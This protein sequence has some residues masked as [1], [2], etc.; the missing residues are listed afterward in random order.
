MQGPLRVGPR[1]LKLGQ[2]DDGLADDVVRGGKVCVEVGHAQG[3]LKQKGSKHP[4]LGEKAPCAFGQRLRGWCR[5][6]GLLFRA[7]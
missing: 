5:A 1:D 2:G 4:N 6:W 3:H 7:L